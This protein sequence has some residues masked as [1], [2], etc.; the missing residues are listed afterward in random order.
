MVERIFTAAIIA[1]MIAGLFMTVLQQTHLTNFIL[2]AETFEVGATDG[3]ADDHNHDGEA[4]SP[5]DGLE[6]TAYSGLANVLTAVA[7]GLL[8]CAGYAMRGQVNWRQGALWGIAGFLSI[9]LAPAL[10][11][12]PELPGAA[13]TPIDQRQIWWVV[14]VVLT[15]VGLA[16]VAFGPRYHWKAAGAFAIALPHLVGAPQP[17]SHVGLAPAELVQAFIYA[18]LIGNA[19]FWIVLGISSGYLFNRFDRDQDSAAV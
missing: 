15:I 1:G 7:F 3:H 14:T 10:G 4:W 8:L 5:Q 9:N 12:P 16:L 18:S 17:D 6:R 19:L 11:L 13:V 2:E